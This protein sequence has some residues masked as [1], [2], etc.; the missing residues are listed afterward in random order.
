MRKK[1]YRVR[2]TDEGFICEY[3]VSRMFRKDVWMPFITW[4]GLS[5][6]YAF[7]SSMNAENALLMQIKKYNILHE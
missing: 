1:I 4:Y 2:K 7:S 6:A 5:K 3:K